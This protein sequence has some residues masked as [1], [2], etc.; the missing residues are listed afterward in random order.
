[1]TTQKQFEKMAEAYEHHCYM[2]TPEDRKKIAASL[3]LPL[4]HFGG[5]AKF[6]KLASYAGNCPRNLEE[7]PFNGI[8]ARIPYVWESR[9]DTLRV[10]EKIASKISPNELESFL[11]E[12]D[13]S[14]GL[15]D[16][17][18]YPNPHETVYHPFGTKFAESW[19]GA[20]ETLESDKLARFVALPNYKSL[21]AKYFEEPVILGMREN[22]WD[23][24]SSLPDPSKSII[25]KLANGSF[26]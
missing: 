23:V 2:Y 25:A 13:S 7:D 17:S 5:A 8:S 9:Q 24:F 4:A 15:R 11:T 22:P 6:T 14:A 20:T 12:F 16:Y 26:A 10:L 1:M 18:S 19:V 3:A 21:M